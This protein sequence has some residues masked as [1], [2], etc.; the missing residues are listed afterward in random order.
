MKWKYHI[1]PAIL[2]LGVL[3][4]LGGGAIL[5]TVPYPSQTNSQRVV[6]DTVVPGGNL[7]LEYDVTRRPKSGCTILI[8]PFMFDGDQLR[9]EYQRFKVPLPSKGG[10]QVFKAKIKVPASAHSGEAIYRPRV[11]WYCNIVQQWWPREFTE[12][13]DLVFT[14]SPRGSS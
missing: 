11:E 2:S 5:Y 10:R 9:H 8:T 4:P 13:R 12:V 14:I 7:V 3:L 6:S 1:L